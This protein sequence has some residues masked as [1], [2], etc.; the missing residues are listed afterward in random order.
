MPIEEHAHLAYLGVI[1][2]KAEFP[3]VSVLHVLTQ[4]GHHRVIITPRVA[5]TLKKLKAR[6]E[7]IDIMDISAKSDDLLLAEICTTLGICLSSYS[8]KKTSL[9]TWDI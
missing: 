6:F 1:A 3:T 8:V 7:L 4:L 5:K 2:R 9:L